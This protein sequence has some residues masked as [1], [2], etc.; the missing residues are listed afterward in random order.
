MPGRL[1][2]RL[3]QQLIDEA[4]DFSSAEP[5]VPDSFAQAVIVIPAC[6]CRLANQWL[7]EGARE[8]LAYSPAEVVKT[9]VVDFKRAIRLPISTSY[10][11]DLSKVCSQFRSNPYRLHGSVIRRGPVLVDEVEG[12]AAYIPPHTD[13]VDRLLTDLYDNLRVTRPVGCG[14][15]MKFSL[16]MMCHL[17]A[18]HPL[19][20]GNGRTARALFIRSAT[21]CG[22]QAEY[23]ALVLSIMHAKYHVVFHSSLM[24]YCLA[25]DFAGLCEVLRSSMEEAR[26]LLANDLCALSADISSGS[27]QGEDIN[28]ISAFVHLS[29][30][31]Y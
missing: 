1:S 5:R 11:A 2:G 9:S 10:R 8:Q 16:L 17:L 23:A 6:G 20:D 13:H 24:S 3:L 7:S 19:T 30:L 22:V 27:R 15:V 28:S 31:I 14:A 29:K 4:A 26:R 18:I 21:R 12:Q 25:G